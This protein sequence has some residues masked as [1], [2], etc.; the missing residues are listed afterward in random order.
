MLRVLAL[1]LCALAI[2]ASAQT[3]LDTDTAQLRY[4]DL[5]H[6]LATTPPGPEHDLFAGVLADRTNHLDEAIHLLEPLATGTTLSPTRLALVL[7]SLADANLKLFRY[8]QAS[9]LYTR[10]LTEAPSGLSPAYL[11][12]DKD[13]ADTIQLLLSAPPQTIEIN[14]PVDLPTH[15]DRLSSI[16]AD[17][18]AHNLTTPWILDTGAN[19]SVVSESFAHQ[20]GLTLSTGIAHTQGATGA[21]NPLH[22]AILDTLTLGTATVHNVVLLVLPDANLTIQSGR[23][24]YTIP[25]I[26]G[27]PV[28]QALGIIRFTHD[29]HFR[30]GPTLRL[31]GDSSPLYMEKL[32]VLFSARTHNQSRP[33][34]FDSGAN[35]TS[36][37]LPYYRDFTA[38]FL[39]QAQGTRN[40]YGAG[41][42]STDH[43]YILDH[44]DL[45]LANRILDLRHIA[46]FKDPQ[47]TLSDAYEGALGR[48]LI[49]SLDSLTLDLIHNRVYAGNPRN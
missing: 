45:E 44:A 39:H 35:A 20:L 25:A 26:L 1:L 22:I 6:D 40:G 31:A 36:F 3:R 11:K 12:D 15:T 30:A 27:Y 48:D 9:A 29:H 24:K 4:D 21:E 47:N 8:A 18:T 23:K 19:F 14:A 37:F 10:L 38:D 16:T 28:F 7:G 42:T 41:G 46:V 17:L 2:P 32:N 34:L 43:V 5:A 33:F 49:N 13:D